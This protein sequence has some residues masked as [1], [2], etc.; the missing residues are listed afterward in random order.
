M[1]RTIVLVI[2]LAIAGILVA[3]IIQ[4]AHRGVLEIP[5]AEDDGG[6]AG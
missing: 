5:S 4:N 2:Y 3:G 6:T 1:I